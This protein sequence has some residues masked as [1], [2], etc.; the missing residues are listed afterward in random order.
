M[1]ASH[2]EIVGIYGG[3]F[4]PIHFGHLHL[5]LELMERNNLNQVWFIPAR[6]NPL[7]LDQQ[8][9]DSRHRL[10]MV[11]LAIADI[12]QFRVLDIDCRR[13]GPSYAIDTLRAVAAEY[14]YQWRLLLGSDAIETFARWREPES[15]VRLAP[16]L[17][18]QRSRQTPPEEPMGTAEIVNALQLGRVSMPILEISSTMVRERLRQGLYC[19][20]LIPAK[21]LDYIYKHH[22]YLAL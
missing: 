3:T 5:A 8:L 13:E 9:I 12:R 7:R 16:P 17:I 18:G 10:E 6:Q 21:V 4:N 19:G 1:S 14:P 20:H 2:E 11:S 22:L 15:I